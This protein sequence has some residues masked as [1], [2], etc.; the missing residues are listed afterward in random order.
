MT[1]NP[2]FCHDRHFFFVLLEHVDSFKLLIISGLNLTSRDFRFFINK[3]TNTVH[4]F[5]IAF[6][7]LI[8]LVTFSVVKIVLTLIP[9]SRFTALFNRAILNGSLLV[10]TVNHSV[11]RETELFPSISTVSRTLYVFKLSKSSSLHSSP[12]PA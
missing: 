11:E 6:V 10:V 1:K 5:K 12:K 7:S 3:D 2:L 4:S 9:S 8:I